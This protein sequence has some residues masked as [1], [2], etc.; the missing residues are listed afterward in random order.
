[1]SIN[2]VLS[3]PSTPSSPPLPPSLLCTVDDSDPGQSSETWGERLVPP[4]SMYAGNGCSPVISPLSSLHRDTSSTLHYYAAVNAYTNAR[5]CVCARV[6]VCVF[7]CGSAPVTISRLFVVKIVSTVEAYKRM[8]L[9]CP[10]WYFM[11][12]ICFSAW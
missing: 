6:Y 7:D 4:C 8:Q 10:L 12:V 5:V 11:L 1:M 3:H 9:I 2:A